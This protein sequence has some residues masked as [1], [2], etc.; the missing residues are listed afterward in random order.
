M[1][2][3]TDNIP[4]ELRASKNWVCFMLLDNPEKGKP[5]K[6]PI[7]PSSLWGARPNAPTTWGT[8]Q[9]AA[10]QIGKTGRCKR[11][12]P[13][14]ANQKITVSGAIAGVGYMFNNAGI[15][16]VDFDHCIDPNTGELN[17]WA[18]SWVERFGSYTEI[19]PS[20]TGLHILCKGNLP[21]KAVKLPQAEMSRQGPVFH[22]DRER[23][24]RMPG[25]NARAGIHQLPCTRS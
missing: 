8:F 12:D 23:V 15:V 9:D 6:V 11:P 20:G 3:Q 18:A 1:T 21:G 19:S 4:A 5:D 10:A 2:L 17:P 25:T 24:R 13:K 16:G 7:N 22:R 14:D